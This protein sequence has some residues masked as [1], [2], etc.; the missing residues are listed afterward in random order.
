MKTLQRCDQPSNKIDVKFIDK[1][2]LVVN[3]KEKDSYCNDKP[4]FDKLSNEIL[5]L[6]L[7]M[8]IKSSKLAC[9]DHACTVVQRL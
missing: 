4:S 1:N 7:E 6:I 8:V 9:P 3:S 5:A 2:T